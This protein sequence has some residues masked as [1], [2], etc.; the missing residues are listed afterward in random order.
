MLL[1][2]VDIQYL[3]FTNT[4]DSVYLLWLRIFTFKSCLTPT[5][6]RLL[7]ADNPS[8]TCRCKSC[9]QWNVTKPSTTQWVANHH[10]YIP[11]KS[12]M[13]QYLLLIRYGV[14]LKCN[15]LKL[16]SEMTH[17]DIIA[18]ILTSLL[19]RTKKFKINTAFQYK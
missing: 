16:L 6:F 17:Y 4:R 9:I 8:S 11:L 3:L 1:H 7:R 18:V 12:G 14:R 5:R 2:S 15:F 19:N 10:R 13:R